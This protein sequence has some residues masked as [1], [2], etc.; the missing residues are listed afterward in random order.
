MPYFS[1]LSHTVWNCKYHIVFCSKY[2][3][4]V[5]TGKVE[6]LLRNELYRLARQKDQVQIEEVNIQ[7]DHVHLVISV[8]PKYA[9]S[10]IMGFLKGKTAIR[11]FNE[12]KQ[13]TA[14]YWGRH[15]WSRGYAVSGLGLNAEQVKKYVAWQQAQDKKG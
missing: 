4:Q 1:K 7:S 10:D 14:Q 9:I 3:Y 12:S 15:I 2:R 5:L 11:L 6:V 8:P 13:L